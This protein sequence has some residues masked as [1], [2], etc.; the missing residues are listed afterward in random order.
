MAASTRPRSRRDGAV[1][2]PLVLGAALTLAACTDDPGSALTRTGTETPSGAECSIPT[3]Q[4]LDGGP[5]KDG[6]PALTNPT[7]VGNGA[8]GTEYLL[9]DDRVVGLELA[10][11]PIA[12]P[13]NI[14]W[15]HEI[16]NLD[17]DEGKLAVT[18]CPLTGSS[19]AFH[20]AAV[21]GGEFG[22]SGLLYQNNLM[23]YD[24]TN[25]ESLWPQMLRGARC[26][27]RDGT[28][29]EMSPVVEMTWDGWR[30]LHPDTRVVSSGTGYGMNYRAYPYGDY[31]QLSNEDP[32]FPMGS[33]DPRRPAKER[34]LG[35]PD[36]TS[37]IG[38][39]FG[40]LDELGALAAV[41]AMAAGEEIV[42]FWDRTRQG[43]MAYRPVIDGQ[44]LTFE[45]RDDS[46]V[47][48]ETGSTWRVDGQATAGPLAGRRL[49]PVAEAFVAFWFAWAAFYPETELWTAI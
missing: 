2:V 11:G 21:S 8:P 17:H 6:I 20:R 10:G 47:D 23:M 22:V 15:W 13:L 3:S 36:G 18:H 5:G 4:I 42:V 1:T 40:E 25:Q 48:V 29:L 24:R 34:T 41:H 30:S 37:G 9:P 32:L 28:P 19:L 39:P 38:F 16:V 12:I 44:A 14:F 7:M 35:I 27:P 49:E 46:L 26:G 43:A 45:V 31:D 33:L